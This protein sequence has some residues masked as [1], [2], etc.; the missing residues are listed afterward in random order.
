MLTALGS[1]GDVAPVVAIGRALAARGHDATIVVLDEYA[2][3]VDAAG[4]RAEPV[5]AGPSAL[6]PDVPL[7]RRLAL[8]QPGAMY[9][10]MLVSFARIAPHT[11]DALLRAAVDADVIVSG[12]AT[13]GACRALA[14]A[15][16]ARHLSVL[17][18]P[19]LPADDSSATSLG[20]P[21]PAPLTRATSTVMW[22]LTRGLMAAHTLE[23]NRQLRGRPRTAPTTSTLVATS[24]VVSPPSPRWPADV[25]QVGHIRSTGGRVPVGADVE[26]FLAAGPPPVVMTF[27]SCPV[28]SAERDREMFIDAARLAGVR[29]VL[30]GA[31]D[32]DHGPDV[33]TA[34]AVDF[35]ELLPRAAAVVHH[36]GAG[37]TYTALAAGTPSVVVPHL[38]DQGYYA[39]RVAALGAGPRGVP[40]WRLTAPRLARLVTAAL[41]ARARDR[42]REVAATLGGVDGAEVVADRVEASAAAA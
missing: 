21:G 3:L 1:E 39:R 37:T 19:L 38:G 12:L 40:R 10:T 23:M 26:D 34:G 11:T 17:Y 33:L 42:A 7:L 41:D 29:L 36:G 30:P 6:W 16:G 28:V 14:G 5:H 9:A 27:G 31:P 15:T 2:H 25:E 13:Q 20:L 18:A 35:A 24:P 8:A 22:T 32:G 4:L